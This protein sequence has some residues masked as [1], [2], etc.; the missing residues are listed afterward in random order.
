[1]RS[2]L[3][4]RAGCNQNCPLVEQLRT[5]VNLGYN[6]RSCHFTCSYTSLSSWVRVLSTIMTLLYYS[7]GSGLS[8]LTVVGL[9]ITPV[10]SER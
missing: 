6:Q 1:M 8:F 10:M 9:C 5:A 2:T 3:L 4:A 7:L